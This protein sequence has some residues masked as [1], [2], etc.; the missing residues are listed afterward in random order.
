MIEK[1]DESISQVL[2]MVLMSIVISALIYAIFVTNSVAHVGESKNKGGSNFTALSK[3]VTYIQL[4]KISEQTIDAR[5]RS[6][7]ALSKERIQELFDQA[8]DVLRGSSDVGST[9]FC[10]STTI[11]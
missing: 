3:S 11:N 6:Q 5:K 4:D 2:I 10:S 8:K 7:K 9:V 1:D